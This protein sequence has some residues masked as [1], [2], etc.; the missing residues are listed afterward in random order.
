ML[1]SSVEARFSITWQT[2]DS[3][4]LKMWWTVGGVRDPY[5]FIDS[6]I[7]VPPGVTCYELGRIA[8]RDNINDM[9][10]YWR[11]D[12]NQKTSS[13]DVVTDMAYSHASFS[14]FLQAA[15]VE[16]VSWYALGD[17]AELSDVEVLIDL[18]P[19]TD[20][21][22]H[23]PLPDPASLFLF[24]SGSCPDLPGYQAF[25]VTTGMP[26]S[27]DMEVVSTTTLY[28]PEPVML[29]VQSACISG[30]EI[31][32]IASG[33]TPY[34]SEFLQGESVT[35]VAPAAAADSDTGYTFRRWI[36][37]GIEQP[38]WKTSLELTIDEPRTVT[39]AY[40]LR[41]DLDDSGAVDLI[42]LVTVR[43][44]LGAACP[45]PEAPVI[46]PPGEN[47][48]A[49]AEIQLQITSES[50]TIE[51]SPIPFSVEALIS[52]LATVDLTPQQP[53]GSTP[54]EIVQL[55]LV[56][57]EPILVTYVDGSQSLW[58][59][60]IELSDATPGAGE[61]TF[62]KT[63]EHLGDAEFYF[64]F[65]PRI[66]VTDLID[67]QEHIFTGIEPIEIT[68]SGEFVYGPLPSEPAFSEPRLSGPQTLSSSVS[69]SS[70]P[71]FDTPPCEPEGGKKTVNHAED[72]KHIH[73]IVF[74]YEDDKSI[75]L[76][77]AARAP[78]D[79]TGWLSDLLRATWQPPPA[80]PGT[81]NPDYDLGKLLSIEVTW[82]ITHTAS[83]TKM[84]CTNGQ[85]RIDGNSLAEAQ[86]I[87]VTH[88]DHTTTIAGPFA[89][90]PP[91]RDAVN[92][93]RPN[94]ARP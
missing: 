3:G 63:Y 29:T 21:L 23:N 68:S 49:D 66:T 41:A 77:Y 65:I 70:V 64:V 79:W 57:T 82:R 69:I 61:M 47:L 87:V 31:D 90:Y 85:W 60:R 8:P 53:E 19:W 91:V 42:D 51:N 13:T 14:D 46:I 92:N 40:N 75:T 2:K 84:I 35:L 15:Q 27:G 83:S 67:E 86:T 48:L 30:I 80:P 7:S 4:H 54:I 26:F 9:H 36:I 78:Y 11:L 38:L 62:T 25:N 33:V 56:A 55:E 12:K 71:G 17:A 6:D 74:T 94:N 76:D 72:R 1:A 93:A 59:M 16:S 50:Y 32:G 10:E 37:D 39:A 73:R 22:K 45:P 18:T 5:P 58:D 24:D 34:A 43:N 28:V 88:T 20:Y 89:S 52:R 44:L 81:S